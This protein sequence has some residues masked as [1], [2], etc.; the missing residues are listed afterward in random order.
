MQ[1]GHVLTEEHAQI[2]VSL[3]LANASLATTVGTAKTVSIL[4]NEMP[5]VNVG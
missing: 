1:T 4:I 3:V 2:A 5:K